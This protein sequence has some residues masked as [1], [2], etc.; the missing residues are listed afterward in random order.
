MKR[1]G[2]LFILFFL[3]ISSFCIFAEEK[4]NYKIKYIDESI[5]KNEEN[6]LI[7]ITTKSGDVYEIDIN[8]NIYKIADN[9]EKAEVYTD[10]KMKNFLILKNDGTLYGLGQQY[11]GI[12]GN[13]K[14]NQKTDTLI[15][16]LDNVKDFIY[17]GSIAYAVK[18]DD[19]LWY[20]GYD[21]KNI[22]YPPKKIADDIK[23][24]ST[25]KELVLIVKN[26]NSLWAVE[27]KSISSTV[28]Q[29][30]MEGIKN[31]ADYASKPWVIKMDDSLWELEY[32]VYE[33]NITI[34][35]SKKIM[36]DVK[37][38]HAS[39]DGNYC[40][41]KIDESLWA[42]GRNT[43]NVFEYG[44]QYIAKPQKIAEDV[45]K[46]KITKDYFWLLK[47]DSNLYAVINEKIEQYY[48]EN[49]FDSKAIAQNINFVIDGEEK[50]TL[51]YKI[52]EQ[53]YFS[54]YDVTQFLE[55]MELYYYDKNETLI[56]VAN[57]KPSEKKEGKEKAAVSSKLYFFGKEKEPFHFYSRWYPDYKGVTWNGYFVDNNFYLSINSIQ[58]LFDVLVSY[59]KEKNELKINTNRERK[60]KID[61]E[62]CISYYQDIYEKMN[63]YSLDT[64]PIAGIETA[65]E[66][67]N[68]VIENRLDKEALKRYYN[69][70]RKFAV[71]RRYSGDIFDKKEDDGTGARKF[72][73]YEN[74][75]FDIDSR[76]KESGTNTILFDGIR[77][78]KNE[79]RYDIELENIESINLVEPS[80]EYRLKK[81]ESSAEMIKKY[82]IHNLDEYM[83]ME[84][85]IEKEQR[86][87][88]WNDFRKEFGKGDTYGFF[89]MEIM[90][91]D[92]IRGGKSRKGYVMVGNNIDEDVE[93]GC[94]YADKDGLEI[95][96]DG[97]SYVFHKGETIDKFYSENETEGIIKFESGN[98]MQIPLKE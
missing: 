74:F 14:E 62:E 21:G 88:L 47:N 96:I 3:S 78:T 20:W 23:K 84:H 85:Q 29:K 73:S 13:L 44:Q 37:E 68:Y 72:I 79:N 36:E 82:N 93:N 18:K 66:V 83:Q 38:A 60:R 27:K 64:S 28:P 90:T 41:I 69:A 9:A 35:N 40:A 24:I 80:N 89:M 33:N 52:N 75:I 49:Y 76:L 4:E 81:E 50:Q 26:D 22:V 55:P 59:D 39:N 58:K 97:K 31:T 48:F 51:C 16:L 54:L 70:Y 19:S 8:Y 17:E 6:G 5:G 56:D 53:Y 30:I 65:K 87:N 2:V 46:A 61:I 94:M 86:S 95:V 32:L 11:C 15:Q 43:N 77:V 45:K 7:C 42:W 67:Q 10:D 71:S 63:H 12:L 34:Q 91:N 98:T 25:T 1:I 57:K 92:D